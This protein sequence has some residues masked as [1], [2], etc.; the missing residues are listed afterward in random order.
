MIP[1]FAFSDFP[2]RGRSPRM[3][4][5]ARNGRPI[6]RGKPASAPAVEPADASPFLAAHFTLLERHAG[7]LPSTPLARL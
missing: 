5:G 1:H 7:Y 4:S 2:R 3:P 6:R